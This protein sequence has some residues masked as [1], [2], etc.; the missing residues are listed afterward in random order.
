MFK[1]IGSVIEVN[2]KD[3]LLLHTNV[4]VYVSINLELDLP[5]AIIFDLEGHLILFPIAFLLESMVVSFVGGK[6]ETFLTSP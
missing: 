6:N 3:T 1:L 2:K 4:K 5:K